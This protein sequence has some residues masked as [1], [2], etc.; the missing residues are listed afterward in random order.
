MDEESQYKQRSNSYF[1]DE[2]NIRIFQAE[3]KH[4]LPRF[5]VITLAAARALVYMGG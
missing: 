1:E 5:K 4:D 3:K 2:E